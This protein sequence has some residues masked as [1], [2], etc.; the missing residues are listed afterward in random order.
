MKQ[1]IV[2]VL[3]IGLFLLSFILTTQSINK[4]EDPIKL[5]NIEIL[6]NTEQTELD[7]K[8]AGGMCF[9]NDY[10]IFGLHLGILDK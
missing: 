4:N 6:A 9:K 8:T 10:P 1:I 3:A 7:C 5:E 2:I